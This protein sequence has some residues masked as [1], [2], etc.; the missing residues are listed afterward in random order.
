MDE[1]VAAVAVL[2]L[3]TIIFV[4][5]KTVKG[6]GGKGAGPTG[7]EEPGKEGEVGERESVVL[8]I[9][10]PD[11]DNPAAVAALVK[12]VIR[13]NARLHGCLHVVLTGRPVNLRTAKTSG[14]PKKI[15]RQDNEENN[16]QHALMV[17]EDA[18]ARIGN[19]LKQ[20]GI[21]RT[22]VTIYD[23][24]VA[25]C[26]PISD[27]V[28]DWDFLFDRKD[29]VTHQ[30]E[31]CGSI[32]TPEEYR[33]LC[34]DI[35]A[36]EEEEREKKLTSILRSYPLVP[37]PTLCEELEQDYVSEVVL[38]LGGPATALVKLFKGDV[39]SEVLPKV[40]GL[41]GMFGSLNPG[42]NTL[43]SNQFNVACD[44][45]AASELIISNLFPEADKYLITTETAKSDNLLVSADDME[46]NGVG[47][48]FVSLQR[49]WE[50]THKGKPQPLFDVLPVMAFLKHF[51]G[52]FKWSRKEATLQVQKE[53]TEV[54]ILT[55]TDDPQYPLASEPTPN[56]TLNKAMFLEFLRK[57]W[58][59]A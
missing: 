18:A 22:M 32:L 56:Q 20:C 53:G 41:Y 2:I 13:G 40:M 54:L 21:D 35:N 27:R 7:E 6:L 43:L 26:A 46:K 28:H 49:L 4:V 42:K 19:Y 57:T 10:A 44:I 36:L 58:E 14:S 5:Y 25:P 52:C 37:L 11:P 59:P 45:E 12:H 34:G 8:F 39:G 3:T 9:D 31:D 16:P 1:I 23:G 30:E 47:S 51:R 24:G 15:I 17:L 38:F 48:Y 50:S 29:L 55:D 33:T